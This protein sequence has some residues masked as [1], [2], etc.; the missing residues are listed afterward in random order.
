[1]TRG[2]LQVEYA[3]TFHPSL[4]E[5]LILGATIFRD[6]ILPIVLMIA[7]GWGLDRKLRF[8]LDTLVRLNLFLFVPAF[9]FV[10]VVESEASGL[11]ELRIVVFTATMIVMMFI[12]SWLIARMRGESRKVRLGRQLSTMFYNSGNFGIPLMALAFPDVGPIVQVFV[13]MTMN[14]STFSIG[15]ILAHAQTEKGG[16]SIWAAFRQ[17]PVYAIGL[18]WICKSL[19]IPVDSI[20]Y[21]WVPLEYL[22]EGLI[23]LSLVTLGVQLSKTKPPKLEGG[24]LW[25]L[26]LRLLGG[27]LFALVMTPLFGF[28]GEAAKVLIVGA[29]APTAINTALIAHEFKADS[30]QAA[31]AVFYSTLLSVISVTVIILLLRL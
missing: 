17:P 16:R 13:L 1:M 20:G 3:D 29:G 10:K 26:S 11:L 15:S 18:A 19:S 6:I 31:A 27:P 22:A 7:L 25:T 24:I 8:N 9:I 5:S 4:M 21:L 28:E 30:R 2:Q 14:I 12:A 23:G